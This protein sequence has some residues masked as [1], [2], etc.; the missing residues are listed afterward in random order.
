MEKYRKRSV[1]I[2]AMLVSRETVGQLPIAAL[3]SLAQTWKVGVMIDTLEGPSLC[4]YGDYLI[5]GSKG[6]YYP[7]KPDI[8][9]EVYE[10]VQI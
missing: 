1:I 10:K 8:F 5:K 4:R 6:E 3:G 7:C 2:E 9:E